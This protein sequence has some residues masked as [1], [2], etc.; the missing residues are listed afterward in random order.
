MRDVRG[1]GANPVIGQ[2][3]RNQ[4]QGRDREQTGLVDLAETARGEEQGAHKRHT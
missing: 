1:G 2:A 4:Q 3:Q